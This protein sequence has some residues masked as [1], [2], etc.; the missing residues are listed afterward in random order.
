[1]QN[2]RAASARSVPF[3]AAT[4]TSAG[5]VEA[6]E[7]A[8]AHEGAERNARPADAEAVRETG[9]KARAE[10]RAAARRR[11]ALTH[12]R[13]AAVVAM[14]SGDARGRDRTPVATRCTKAAA[15]VDRIGKP[16]HGR[17]T[18]RSPAI[19]QVPVGKRC[20]VLVHT[21]PE[22]T[23]Q[24]PLRVCICDLGADRSNGDDHLLRVKFEISQ[25]QTTVRRWR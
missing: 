10:N 20:P 4:A 3:D 12:P 16:L 21:W 23:W 6:S 19:D 15:K 22:N 24:I 18:D 1:M 17:A 13:R 11:R 7:E 5:D 8:S 9:G 14:A 2:R 25:R